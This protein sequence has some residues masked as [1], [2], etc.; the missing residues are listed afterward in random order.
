[1]AQVVDDVDTG[2]GYAENSIFS[3][4]RGAVVFKNKSSLGAIF[5][6]HFNPYPFPTLALE[7]LRLDHCNSEWSTGRFISAEFK[8]KELY[9]TYTTHLNDIRNWA[10]MNQT[11]VDNLCFKWYTRASRAITGPS[12]DQHQPISRRCFTQ[13]TGRKDWVDGQ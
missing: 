5:A 9:K 12:L 1:M 8:E 7:F 6:S 11:V 2:E 4:I 3:D 13:R 10:A